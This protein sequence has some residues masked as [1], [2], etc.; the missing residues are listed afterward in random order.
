MDGW[1]DERWLDIRSTAVRNIMRARIE[2]AKA[3]GCHA[4]EPDNVD[5]FDNNTGFGLTAAH[6]LDFNRF[7]AATAHGQGLSVGLKNAL[8]LIPQ[9]VGDFDWAL[10]EECFTYQECTELRPFITAGKAVFHAEY[11]TASQAGAVCNVTRPLG[12]STIVK[13][14][15]LAAGGSVGAWFAHA[16]RCWSSCSARSW[17]RRWRYSRCSR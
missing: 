15:D 7:L 12:L 8:A 9:L 4:V 17:C 6:Q 1:P 16:P 11:V 5:G 13:R 10:N 3:K 2:L 14:L